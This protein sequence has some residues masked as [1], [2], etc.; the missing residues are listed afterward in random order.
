[1]KVRLPHVPYISQKIAIDLVNSGFVTLK[2]GLEGVASVANEILTNDLM[3]EKS[4]DERA[5]ELI[6]ERID[7]MDSMQVD[8]KNMFW[9][10]KKRLAEDLNFN[11]TYEDR[12]MNLSHEILETLWKKDLMDYVVSDNKVK[13]V[14]YASIENYLKSYEKIEDEVIEKIENY[15]RKLI[16]GTQE[17]DLVFE[18]LYKE[19]LRKKGM[20]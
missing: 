17:Y 16:P 9:L 7:E 6:D 8:K 14:I 2:S 10:I 12:Y 13:N 19:E 3:K 1:M 20:F 5:N 4:I 18:E 15:K 11:L